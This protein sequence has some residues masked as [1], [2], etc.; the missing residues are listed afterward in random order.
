MPKVIQLQ[1]YNKKL[2]RKTTGRIE[3][4]NVTEQSADLFFYGDI[5]DDSW[6]SW[7][8][9]EAQ[10]PMNIANLLEEAEGKALNIY[11]N[12]GGGHVF[13]GMAIYNMLKRFEGTKTVYV[14]G[15]AAS[16]AS[17]ICLAG[18]RIIIP[19]TAYMMIHKPM[20]GQYGNATELRKLAD[21][22][23][24]IEV[25]IMNAYEENLNEGVDIETVRD[26]VHKETW[27]TGEEA[28]EYFNIELSDVS[29]A[30][31]VSNLAD[32]YKNIPEGLVIE[33][34]QAVKL[35]GTAVKNQ[36]PEPP[37]QVIEEPEQITEEP[38]Q[39]E[40]KNKLMLE[41]DLL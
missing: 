18:D 38:D 35:P 11:I 14:D 4:K 2:D 5:V 15:M 17:V 9:D 7:Y 21:T 26:M 27:L 32:G 12:S 1:Y 22:L 20:S 30:A 33:N 8:G 24:R 19:K 10:Y 36:N 25:G 6:Y 39:E 23:D 41:L 28:A 3:V 31:C 16:I 40:V 37:E 13:G 34:N 29:A